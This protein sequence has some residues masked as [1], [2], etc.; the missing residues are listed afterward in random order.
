MLE[1]SL[2]SIVTLSYDQKYR[3]LL[4]WQQI[5]FKTMSSKAISNKLLLA[6][7]VYPIAESM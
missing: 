4:I 3:E 5:K 1:R 2:H 6:S 7:A